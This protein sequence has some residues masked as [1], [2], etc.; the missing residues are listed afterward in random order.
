MLGLRGKIALHWNY[1][2]NTNVPGT[3]VRP[4]I[5]NY[6]SWSPGVSIVEKWIAERFEIEAGLRYEFEHLLVKRFDANNNLLKPEFDFNNFSTS[7]GFHWNVTR[8]V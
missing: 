1:Q 7:I 8:G 6:T 3:G 4:L 5:P 2:Q